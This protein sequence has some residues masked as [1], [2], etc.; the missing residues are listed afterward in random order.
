MCP[1]LYFLIHVGLNKVK[2]YAK[3]W[4]WGRGERTA[5]I[6][7][8][9]AKNSWISPFR[10]RSPLN[11]STDFCL[12]TTDREGPRAKRFSE[13]EKA[14]LC[15]SGCCVPAFPTLQGCCQNSKQPPKLFISFV[16]L[17]NSSGLKGFLQSACCPAL[18]FLHLLHSTR[19]LPCHIGSH[20]H[21]Y[22]SSLGFLHLMFSVLNT[23]SLETPLATLVSE[24]PC[25]LGIASLPCSTSSPDYTVWLVLS[26]TA[27]L[28]TGFPCFPLGRFHRYKTSV[29]FGS[30]LHFWHLKTVSK[31]LVGAWQVLVDYVFIPLCEAGCLPAVWDSL[32]LLLK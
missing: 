11:L 26:L 5:S 15:K 14:S 10:R 30:L 20:G 22:P 7:Q 2:I 17:Q 8:T 28:H 6:S 25:V 12:V 9:S 29:M 13:V 24:K 23:P 4:P 1:V 3:I 27:G 18:P 21:I 16:D 31:N 19:P 32:F